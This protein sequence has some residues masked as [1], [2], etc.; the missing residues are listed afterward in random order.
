[1]ESWGSRFEEEEILAQRPGGRW[2]RIIFPV[3]ESVSV[4]EKRDTEVTCGNGTNTERLRV[5]LREEGRSRRIIP[6]HFLRGRKLTLSDV[7]VVA[8]FCVSSG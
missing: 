5:P 8:G 3:A 6:P 1:M 4:P 7:R 2:T